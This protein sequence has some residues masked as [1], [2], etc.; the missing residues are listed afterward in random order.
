MIICIATRSR[1]DIQPV[2]SNPWYCC[3]GVFLQESAS[4]GKIKAPVTVHADGTIH[5]DNEAVK[6]VITQLARA[7]H[8]NESDVRRTFARFA[9]PKSRAANKLGVD[10]NGT[11][12]G[13]SWSIWKC[14]ATLPS[15][16]YC[17]IGSAVPL[18]L[19]AV[20]KQLDI[21]VYDQQLMVLFEA[22]DRNRDG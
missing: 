15:L 16:K 11:C 21:P 12:P 9:D 2:L 14:T 1:C 3:S 13:R 4:L 18:G 6:W 7:V 10:F 8:R 20:L 22:L 17:S 5:I 19:R